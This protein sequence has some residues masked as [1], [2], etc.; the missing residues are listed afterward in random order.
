M[1]FAILMVV[2]LLKGHELQMAIGFSVIW[3]LITSA[4]YIG[5]S[6]YKSRKLSCHSIDAD[7]PDSK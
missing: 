7:E 4:I 2:E 5:I 1:V 3:G 6:I